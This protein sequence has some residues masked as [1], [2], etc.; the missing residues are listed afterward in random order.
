MGTKRAQT[1]HNR[2]RHKSQTT[3]FILQEPRQN[4]VHSFTQATHTHPSIPSL[5]QQ[6]ASAYLVGD[7]ASEMWHVQ[8]VEVER[9]FSGDVL[10]EGAQ[11]HSTVAGISLSG[12]VL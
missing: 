4:G 10:S 1:I 2:D 9:S 12:D 8:L 6:R 11:E 3:G 5:I 7:L